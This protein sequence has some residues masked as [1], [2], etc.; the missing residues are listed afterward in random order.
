MSYISVNGNHRLEGKVQIQG[1]KNSV[2][3]ILSASLL[4]N[5]PCVIHNC[6]SISDVDACI[7]ILKHLGCKVRVEDHTIMVDP[8]TAGCHEIPDDYMREMR[9]SIV[10]LGAILAKCGKISFSLPGGCELG[11]RPI[12]LHVNALGQMG[13]SLEDHHGRLFC[14]VKN[15]GMTGT[16]ILLPLPSVGATENIMI[17]A[18]TAK[19]KTIIRNAAREP[20]IVDLARFLNG[21]GARISGH[22]EGTVVI[23]GVPTLHGC[24]HEIIPDR[25]VVSTYMA[26]VAMTGGDGVLENV[27]V[28]HIAPTLPFF[29]QSGCRVSLRGN[30][31]RIKAP[32]S[33]HPMKN[34]MTGYF[35]GF[36]TDAQPLLMAM[37]TVANGTSIFVENIFENRY[38][39]V[40][41]L[42]RLGAKIKIEGRMAVVEGAKTLSGT[43]VKASDL[44]GGA[45]LVLAGLT[46]EGQTKI[47]H[48]DYIKRGYEDIVRDLSYL[49]A[50]ISMK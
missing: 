22:G 14:Q 25:I 43:T 9:S 44:R 33:L 13:V 32:Q 34:V 45:A 40:H 8:T 19:G 50:D 29:R 15:E 4:C 39:H 35:P 30:Q 47:Y 3:P 16:E 36:P 42:S 28:Q 6:P 37:A 23:E 38:H 24:E 20:E 17:A 26:A 10:F 31:L 5:S 21:C 48:T 18:A 11:P 1:A 27:I 46:A 12:D 2:L 49:G 41:E 7:K